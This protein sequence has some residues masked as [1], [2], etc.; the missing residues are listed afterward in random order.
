MPLL[1]TNEGDVYDAGQVDKSVEALTFAAGTRGFVF[2]DIRPRVQRNPMTKTVDL[3]YEID[4]APRVYI[5][6]IN[7][8]G[9]TR[10]RDQVIRREFRLAE[11]DAFNRVLADRSRTRIRGLGFFK[12]VTIAEDPGSAPDRTT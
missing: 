8:V 4:E 11:G 10:T 6:R 9:N 12:D 5:E 1:L 7:I 3:F 2:I